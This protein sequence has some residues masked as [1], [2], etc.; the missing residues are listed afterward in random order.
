MKPLPLAKDFETK[1]VLR[2][3]A[4][5]H[6]A[7]A[8]LK[9]AISSI[10]NEN[11]LIETLTLREAR[12]SSAIENIISTFDEVYQSNLAVQQFASAEAK[13]VHMYAKAL[14][15]GFNLVSK[16]GLL[17]VNYILQIQKE[18]EQNNAG[19]RKLPGTKLLNDK[20]GEV[21][22]TPPQEH[23]VIADL[24]KNLEKF[25]NDDEMMEADALVKMA[26]IHHQF[27]SIH[28]FY[29]GN[30]RTG[31]IINILYLI[32]KGLLH[33]PIL[34]LSRYIIQNRNDYYGLLQRVRQKD[35]W[36]S[37]ILF[38][39]DGVEKTANETI[40]LIS[41]IKL[42][43]QQYKDVLKSQLPKMYSQDLINNIFKYPYT[44][45]EYLQK[46]LEVSRNTAIRYLEAL[47][48]QGLV[49]K[50]KKGRDN[51]YI[52]QPLFNLLSGQKEIK[53]LSPPKSISIKDR[54]QTETI[55]KLCE[56]I[57]KKH[58][59][60]FYYESTTNKHK[61]W[62]IVEPYIVGIK[63]NGKG[64]VFL[65]GW[66]N[67]TPAQIKNKQEPDMRHYL[68]NSIDKIKILPQKFNK[69]N[70]SKEIII[71]TPSIEVICKVLF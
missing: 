7:L 21:V 27:E 38:M 46:D 10:P 39:L 22:Y 1:A 9:G 56:A 6:K 37:W 57:K 53:N 64:N 49:V 69:L 63:D 15:K 17:T 52:N 55:K 25:I 28:P 51:F 32:Q 61:D 44:K 34:Y 59:V 54:K 3:T 23:A 30:G 68:I 24:M 5:A 20:T 2:K 11:I 16:H 26:I 70:V 62:R 4:Q 45:I 36:E 58:L 47:V 65:A 12:E 43:M 18:V 13:E 8:E 40:L 48:N 41:N 31:R 50:K 35:E 67:P 14:K 71:Q 66:F 60:K 19:F 29:D 33:L 42:L